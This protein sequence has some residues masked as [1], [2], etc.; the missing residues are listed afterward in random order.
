[1]AIGSLVP[2]QVDRYVSGKDWQTDLENAAAA[3]RSE[4]S[5]TDM[6][7]ADQEEEEDDDDEDNDN[8]DLSH[9]SEHDALA[10]LRNRDTQMDA[11]SGS[12]RKKWWYTYKYRPILGIVALD[13]AGDGAAQPASESDDS[14]DLPSLEAVLVERPLWDLD[15]P[16]RYFGANE[17]ERR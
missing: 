2:Q 3:T 6:A 16:E 7:D 15:L 1:M 11:S 14:T 13:P 4:G 8:D 12:G 9:E 5:D 10:A 17:A